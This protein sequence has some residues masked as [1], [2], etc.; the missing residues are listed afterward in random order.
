[1]RILVLGAGGM[2]G[3]KLIQTLPGEWEVWGTVRAPA[4]AYAGY[5]FFNAARLVSGVELCDFDTLRQAIEQVGPDWIINCIGII[6]QLEAAKDPLV[7]LETNSLL[8]HRLARLCREREIHLIHIS[9]DCVFSGHKGNYSEADIS[10]AE[11]LYGRSKFLGEINDGR[12]LT[13]RTSIIGRELQ[14]RHG[15]VEWFLNPATRRVQG[16]TR[17]VYS[18]F[19]TLEFSKIIAGLIADHPEL[20]GLYQVASDPINKYELLLLLRE[21]YH[22]EKEIEPTEQPVIDRSLDSGLFRTAAGY[23]PPS[24]RELTEAMA[25]D[26][27]PYDSWK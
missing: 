18:G 21:A 6:K 27:T 1:M 23:Q 25:L 11:D 9:T 14:T 3:H 20:T 8:P 16:F 10:D 5:G 7:S 4:A 26:P 13:L 17:A 24:W 12:A 19:T 2:L 22:L 15:L